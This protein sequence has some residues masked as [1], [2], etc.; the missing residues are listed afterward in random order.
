VF[1]AQVG[2]V[3]TLSIM[4]QVFLSVFSGVNILPYLNEVC[5]RLK[6]AIA[7]KEGYC[8]KSVWV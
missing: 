3:G 2:F 4:A 6:K 8:H 5:G 1:F 7:R